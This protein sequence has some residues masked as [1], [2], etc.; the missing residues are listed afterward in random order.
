MLENDNYS[1]VK[2]HICSMDKKDNCFS[3]KLKDYP[4][5]LCVIDKVNKV[6]IDVETAHQYPYIRIINHQY[7]LDMDIAEIKL[8]NSGER[9]GCIAYAM[10]LKNSLDSKILRR[11]KY[12]V[13]LLSEGYT[14]PDGNKELTNDEY[15]D[16][17]NNPK[18]MKKFNKMQIKRK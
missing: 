8:L 6:V 17:V 9:V 5:R 1:I 3:L 12:I 2:M 10:L 18:T 11:C 13:K 15:L 14:F 16:V 4:E 7:Y